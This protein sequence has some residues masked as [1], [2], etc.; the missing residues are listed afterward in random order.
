MKY[1]HIWKNG[2]TGMA[3]KSEHR[4]DP[5]VKGAQTVRTKTV[6]KT[7]VKEPQSVYTTFPQE[8]L[9]PSPQKAKTV[10]ADKNV[11]RNRGKALAGL[12]RLKTGISPLRDPARELVTID[13]SGRMVLPKKI[14]DRFDANR[15]EVRATEDRI[16]LIPIEPLSSL[17]GALPDID[18][19]KIYREHDQEVDE[20]DAE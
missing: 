15:F 8:R 10:R 1:S 3:Q 12:K 13:R 7:T 4:R 5:T 19:E 2:D 17:L 14:R 11:R 9:D 6:N 16:E 18:L 20:E